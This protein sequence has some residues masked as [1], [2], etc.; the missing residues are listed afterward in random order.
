MTPM[1]YDEAVA[2]IHEW[3]AD[4]TRDTGDLLDGL[5]YRALEHEHW[6]FHHLLTKFEPKTREWLRPGCA[7]IGYQFGVVT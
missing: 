4:E 7:L 6:W 5:Q 3:L 2:F 1:T